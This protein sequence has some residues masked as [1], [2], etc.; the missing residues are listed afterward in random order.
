MTAKTP[1]TRRARA[2]KPRTPAKVFAG[3]TLPAPL[4]ERISEIARRHQRSRSAEIGIAVREYVE[5]V[6]GGRYA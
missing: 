1:T 4:C 5:R 3:L 2:A 6:E